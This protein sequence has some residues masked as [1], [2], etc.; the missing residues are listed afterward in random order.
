MRVVS[1]KEGRGSAAR[2]PARA[3]RDAAP[4]R[5]HAR[6]PA[7]ARRIGGLTRR[8]EHDAYSEVLDRLLRDLKVEASPASGGYPDYDES[9]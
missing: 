8:K 4:G 1:A 6:E 5:Y 3:V 2:G 9:P 7:L